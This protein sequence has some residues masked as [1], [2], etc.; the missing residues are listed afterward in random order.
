MAD[1]IPSV[2][3]DEQLAALDPAYATFMSGFSAQERT[4][5]P[6]Q[7]AAAISRFARPP[8]PDKSDVHELL[9]THNFIIG[10]FVVHALNAEPWRWLTLS[11][12]PC[13]L[14]RILY[15]SGRPP[16]LVAFNDV[17]HLGEPSIG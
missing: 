1:A 12:D 13:G 15:R 17:G 5:G 7:M 16:S 11:Q 4:D 10:G 9:V 8:D 2:P 3:T 6:V 14:T